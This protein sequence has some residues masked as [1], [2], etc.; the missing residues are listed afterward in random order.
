MASRSPATGPLFVSSGDPAADR[1][2]QSAL[3]LAARG[4]LAGAVEVLVQ[5]V[6]LAP[7][8]A[9]AWFALAA[10]REQLGDRAGAVAAFEQ[11]CAA[12]A[13]DYH[14][15]RLHLARLGAAAAL[16]EMTALYVR[17]LFDHHA[18][19]F[20]RT[21]VERLGYRGP[22]L[23]RDAVGRACESAARPMRFDAM[24][25]LGCGTGLAGAAFRPHVAHLTGVDLSPGMIDAARR[26]QHYDRLETAELNAFLSAQA[27]AGACYDL[28]IAAD[29][30]AYMADF[31]GACG[32]IGQVLAPDGLFGFTVETHAGAGVILG[33]TLR[34][35]HAPAHVDEVL[36]AAGFAV[37]A[38]DPQPIRTEK[39]VPVPSL[40]VVVGH[41]EPLAFS[42]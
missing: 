33:E 25:D 3:G 32:R 16:P 8:F 19:S 39:G 15:A 2:Y 13:D 22:A 23:L 9:T 35:A 42:R 4:D 41:N 36:A 1:R 5:A 37:L 7:A 31:S 34:Y 18:P 14:G 26:K 10:M 40:V 6:E 12:D 29:V 11:A 30:F 24:L 21:L 28:V 27:A 20:D 38:A 17:R